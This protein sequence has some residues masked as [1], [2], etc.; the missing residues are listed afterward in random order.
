MS[1]IFLRV[2]PSQPTHDP[3][4]GYELSAR[5][6][7]RGRDPK[8]PGREEEVDFRQRSIEAWPSAGCSFDRSVPRF[9][10]CGVPGLCAAVGRGPGSSWSGSGSRENFDDTVSLI[11][12]D[13]RSLTGRHERFHRIATL[14]DSQDRLYMTES[15][16]RLSLP[17]PARSD[18]AVP[19]GDGA[20]PCGVRAGTPSYR[21]CLPCRRDDGANLETSFPSDVSDSVGFEAGEVELAD[22]IVTPSRSDASRWSGARWCSRS[23]RRAR[24]VVAAIGRQTEHR[25]IGFILGSKRRGIHVGLP[26]MLRAFG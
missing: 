18:D 12:T 21:V 9:V 8:L 16:A 13:A 15:A 6:R 1:D 25:A 14:R 26:S 20:V 22:R 4:R 2:M 10:R 17:S 7:R 23:A 5:R 24:T 3:C 19:E 11:A